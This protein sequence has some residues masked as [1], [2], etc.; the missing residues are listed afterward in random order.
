MRFTNEA[1]TASKLGL[2]FPRSIPSLSLPGGS[3]PEGPGEFYYW[4]VL[5]C[6]LPSQI[7]ILALIS[8]IA[9]ASH[10]RYPIKR[11]G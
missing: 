11:V 6:L 5:F 1:C 4:W 10:S 7:W 9:H 8:Q 3:L 2:L